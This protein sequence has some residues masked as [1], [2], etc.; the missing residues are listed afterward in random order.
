MCLDYH[1]IMYNFRSF[2]FFFEAYLKN[3]IS[4]D[5]LKFNFCILRPRLGCFS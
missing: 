4:Y 5:F 3:I 1:S 2:F